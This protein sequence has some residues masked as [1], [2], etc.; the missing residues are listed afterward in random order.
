MN[1]V[2]ENS[3]SLKHNISVNNSKLNCIVKIR[4]NDECK[5]GHQDFSI[6]AVFWETNKDRAD[7]NM[8]CGGCCH[9]DILKHFPDLKIFV[10]LHLCDYLGIPMYASANGF[11]HL[12][13]GFD[14]LNGKTQKQYFCDYYRVTSEQYDI[15]K[16]SQ[17]AEHFG[18][19][20]FDL[21]ILNQWK[22]QADN[23]IKVLESF[24]NKVFLVD[25]VKNQFGMSSEQLE[26]EKKKINEGYYSKDKIEERHNEKIKA[27]KNAFILKA[28]E[29][30]DKKI[31]NA[32]IEY[33]IQLLVLKSGLSL[34]NT[35]FYSHSNTLSFNWKSYEPKI[36]EKQFR[37]F[38]EKINIEEFQG[39]TVQMA[40]LKIEYSPL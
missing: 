34:K 10:D 2:L 26:Q 33:K 12:K 9:D 22:E 31:K 16:D 40:D 36:T 32:N 1:T 13:Q 27:E 37:D 15:L 18:Y 20:L 24:T 4:L 14:R 38:C 25:S 21:G 3:N 35:I 23:A 19:L 39:L 17:S 30:R 11:Y 6:T 28:R 8:I 5:N 29:E 7:K